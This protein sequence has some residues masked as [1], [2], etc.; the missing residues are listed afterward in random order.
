[1]DYCFAWIGPYAFWNTL[2]PEVK[3]ALIGAASTMLVGAIGFGGLF[4]QMRSQGKQ[5]RDA[6]AEN[7]RRRLKAAMYEDAVAICRQVA[8][9]SIELSNALRM[10]MLQLEYTAQAHAQGQPV[11][12][13]AARFPKL[14]SLNSDF[15]DAVL[16]FIFLVEERRIVDPR[17][18]VFRTAMSVVLHDVSGAQSKFVPD[19]MPSIPTEM[20]DGTLFP[21][22]PPTVA[23]AAAIKQLCETYID[24]LSDATMYT[25]DFLVEMQNHLL[26]DLFGK[27]VVHR[28]PINP[29]KKVITL[30]HSEDLETWFSNSTA[31]GRNIAQIEAQTAAQYAVP[32]PA[33]P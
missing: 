16:K 29:Q 27:A 17:M 7:E 26:G 20:P 5:S 32:A 19:V 28:K 22:A 4:L 9:T 23:H 2:G 8:D 11:Q 21:W 31:W 3:S 25:E 18:L 6:I 10:M 12:P 1:M 13:P 14:L 24:A 33:N 15:A 30:A